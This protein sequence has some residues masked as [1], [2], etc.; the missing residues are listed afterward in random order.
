MH[1]HVFVS[2][3][4]RYM[5]T[6]SPLM[7]SREEPQAVIIWEVLT[8]QKKRGFHCEN[9]A[10]WPIFKSATSTHCFHTHAATAI[11]AV[12]FG[13]TYTCTTW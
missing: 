8:G 10:V 12:L 3:A 4:V 13:P 9:A 6:F 5:V 1:L 2:R 11:S 7:D